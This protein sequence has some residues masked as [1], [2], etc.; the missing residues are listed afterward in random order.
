MSSPITLPPPSVRDYLR[1][2]KDTA[3][4]TA[5]HPVMLD[6][7]RRGRPHLPPLPGCDVVLDSR[8]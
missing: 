7:T 8:E 4:P 2:K 6:S 1:G 5:P 3:A